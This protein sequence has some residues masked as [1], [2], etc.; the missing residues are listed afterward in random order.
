MDCKAVCLSLP[1]L[2]KAA[3]QL[4]IT[5]P[6]A[7]ERNPASECILVPECIP[8]PECI[9]EC[10]PALSL[11]LTP[12]SAQKQS[13]MQSP[14]CPPMLPLALPLTPTKI[15][16]RAVSL[17][18]TAVTAREVSATVASLLM[19]P[20]GLLAAAS[21]LLPELLLRGPAEGMDKPPA[22]LPPA[23]APSGA[24]TQVKVIQWTA[25]EETCFVPAVFTPAQ[26]SC[27]SMPSTT[28]LVCDAL[29]PASSKPLASS[30][31]T[32][33]DGCCCTIMAVRRAAAEAPLGSMCN[34]VKAVNIP[35]MV[36]VN[37]VIE[38]TVLV[39]TSSP[40]VLTQLTTIRCV[41]SC[42]MAVAMMPNVTLSTYLHG[43]GSPAPIANIVASQA[44]VAVTLA[45]F[46]RIRMVAGVRRTGFWDGVVMKPVSG[47]HSLGCGASLD[48]SLAATMASSHLLS[49]TT[50][51]RLT[52]SR[53]ALLPCTLHVFALTSVLTGN[54]AWVPMYAYA[55]AKLLARL[56]PS[57]TTQSCPLCRH[58]FQVMR[59]FPFC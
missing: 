7:S 39:D 38:S 5:P 33:S 9:P 30:Q 46:R 15:G 13:H 1:Q 26:I 16:T 20:S 3:Q 31:V 23:S 51:G 17:E 36:Q 43:A 27:P 18:L 56:V 6:S 48:A 24:T 58:L 57:M 12:A 45:D 50:P 40:A 22:T 53:S 49:L 10:I 34:L 59:A 2:L 37:A 4:L 42:T 47:I 55:D 28:Q 35:P 54:Y 11:D 29:M 8:A 19:M 52:T 14:G 21:T 41:I 25:M 32:A 44:V